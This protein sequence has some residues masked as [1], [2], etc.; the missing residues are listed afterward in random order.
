MDCKEFAA[1]TP[2]WIADELF[3]KEANRFME[4]MEAC[5]ECREELHIQFLVKEGMERLENGESFNLEEELIT[6]V[7]KYKKRLIHQHKMNVV[8]YW[9]EAIAIAAMAFIIALVVIMKF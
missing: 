6:K 2:L 7:D 3:G 9:M 8:I 1:K 5:D 4:H